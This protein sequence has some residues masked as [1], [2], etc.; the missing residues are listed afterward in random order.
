ME[1]SCPVCGIA[2]MDSDLDTPEE[3]YFCPYCS[4]ELR[5]AISISAPGLQIGWAP[6]KVAEQIR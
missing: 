4:T 1:Y 2:L 3:E 6:A 5:P